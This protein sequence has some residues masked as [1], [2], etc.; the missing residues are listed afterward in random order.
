MR[1]HPGARHRALGVDGSSGAST[2][3]EELI[4]QGCRLD[5]SDVMTATTVREPPHPHRRAACRTLDLTDE[6]GLGV[7]LAVQLA[8]A[9]YPLPAGHEEFLVLRMGTMRAV[10]LAGHGRWSGA[11][12]DGEMRSG[13]GLATAEKQVTLERAA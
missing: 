1:C 6:A 4:R 11:F 2:G 3:C 10:Q 9:P 5:V 7:A 8:N 12:V 13:L